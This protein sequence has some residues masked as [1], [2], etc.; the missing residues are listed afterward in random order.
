MHF[1]NEIAA[2]GQLSYIGLPL[3]KNV[4]SS[5]RNGIELSLHARPFKKLT[6]NTQA[7]FSHNRIA[8]YT[9]DYDNVTY[10]DVSP[11]LAPTAVINQS[12]RYEISSHVEIEANAR[13]SDRSF[14]TNTNDRD[15]MVAASL[16]T[17]LSVKL[18][19]M[20][21]YSLTLMANNIFD[22]KY[23]TA[24]YVANNEANYFAMATRNYYVTLNIK[25]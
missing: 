9:S 6:T 10:K 15:F 24:G 17:N 13:Y 25:F 1:T 14:L 11:L 7:N 16:I 18:K 12:V 19:F 5:F 4:A 22:Q 21:N 3:R 20:E 2:I 8:E 23:Y